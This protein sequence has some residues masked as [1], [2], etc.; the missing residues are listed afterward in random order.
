MKTFSSTLVF[1]AVCLF[2]V[3]AAPPENPVAPAESLNKTVSLRKVVQTD[4]P[5]PKS[6][7]G[8]PTKPAEGHDPFYPVSER[9]FGVKNTPRPT[10]SAANN[11]AIVFNGISG[12]KDRPFAMINGRTFAEGEEAPV[13]TA[14]GRVRVLLVA[15][16]DDRAIVEV[17]GERRELTFQ[18]R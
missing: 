10:P 14:S 5:I 4:K 17:A 3:Q 16:K 13:N 12:S 2:A 8:M 1:T 7:F 9:L 6:T 15:I 18:G 11:T